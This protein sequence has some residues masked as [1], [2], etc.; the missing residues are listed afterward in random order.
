MAIKTEN[1]RKKKRRGFALLIAVVFTSV[2]LAVSI[3]LSSLG[4]KQTIL[5]SAAIDSQDAFYVADA[6][7]ECVLYADQKENLFAYDSCSSPPCTTTMT[8]D[9]ATIEVSQL[10]K[11]ASRLT[12]TAEFSFDED[13]RCA[14]ITVYKPPISAGTTYLFAEGYNVSCSSIGTSLRASARGLK[15]SY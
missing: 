13:L 10:T 1:K 11:T 3:A 5:A 4:Y 7:L 6:A 2:M 8:C 14:R 9:G 15:A 12:S